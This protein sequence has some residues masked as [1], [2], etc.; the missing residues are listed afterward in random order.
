MNTQ[1]RTASWVIREKNGGAVIMETFDQATVN[2]LNTEKYEAV[3]IQEHL[4]SLNRVIRFKKI[5]NALLEKHYGIH[6]NDTDM[7]DDKTVA[8]F[9]TAGVGPFKAVA[10][11]A[12]EMDLFR[13]DKQGFYGVPSRDAITEED[14][15]AAI[16]K[17]RI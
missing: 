3:P 13:I 10:D 7:Y 5:A 8:R 12:D 16:S 6:I 15:L 17:L 9:M 2:A 11:W 1:T 4:V 14:E